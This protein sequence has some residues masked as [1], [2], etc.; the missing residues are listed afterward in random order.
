MNIEEYLRENG[1]SLGKDLIRN[2]NINVLDLAKMISENKNI[3][4]LSFA[5]RYLRIDQ[6]SPSLGRASPSFLREFITYTCFGINTDDVYHKANQL[7]QS[8]IDI[9]LEKRILASELA[10]IIHKEFQHKLSDFGVLIAGD[11]VYGMSHREKRRESST[12]LFVR[13]SDID[14]V[15]LIN[16]NDLNLKNK[17]EDRILSFKYIWLKH[18]KIQ[19]ELD[20]IVKTPTDIKNQL[21]MKSIKD[22]IATKVLY[23]SQ[24]L[25]Q[26]QNIINI[27]KET[28]E[29][30]NA[31]KILTDIESRSNKERE[32]LDY[33]IYNGQISS[34][35]DID[36][37]IFFSTELDE[38]GNLS[39]KKTA[40]SLQETQ[41]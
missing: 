19:E 31:K 15:F 10:T 33:K 27:V 28:M 6:N 22:I 9:S 12:N 41:K 32:D 23:E 21:E 24:I 3:I 5:N 37:S 7:R 16:D 35:D 40:P 1:P 30:S 20:F 29:S 4:K 34:I 14:L 39:T 8:H 2:F 25:V 36:A 26:Q 17:L 18:P 13:G 38:F 11:V